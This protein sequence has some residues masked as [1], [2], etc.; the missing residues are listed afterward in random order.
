VYFDTENK[1]NSSRLVEVACARF[2]EVGRE[3]D[4]LCLEGDDVFPVRFLAVLWTVLRPQI[5]Y[6]CF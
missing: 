5:D 6:E 1:F 2:P 4:C 3:G